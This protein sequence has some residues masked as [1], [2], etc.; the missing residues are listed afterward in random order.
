MC[1]QIRSKPRGKIA[2]HKVVRGQE[3]HAAGDVNCHRHQV[4]WRQESRVAVGRLTVD[5]K[6]AQVSSRSKFKDN[7]QLLSLRAHAKQADHLSYQ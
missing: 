6:R 3:H 7:H 2:V 4:K 1:R 5:Q